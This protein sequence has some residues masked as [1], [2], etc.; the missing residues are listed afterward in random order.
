MGGWEE[1]TFPYVSLVIYIMFTDS[2]C[3]LMNRQCDF[4]TNTRIDTPVGILARIYF[5][6]LMNIQNVRNP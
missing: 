2:I 6:I 4:G 3:I 5:H 1:K